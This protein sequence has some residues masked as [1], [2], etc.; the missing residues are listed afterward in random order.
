MIMIKIKQTYVNRSFTFSCLMF[1][2][3]STPSSSSGTLN[4]SRSRQKVFLLSTFPGNHLEFIAGVLIRFNFRKSWIDI[5]ENWAEWKIT[6]TEKFQIVLTGTAMSSSSSWASASKF[7][8]IKWPEWIA[9]LWR[10]TAI[11]WKCHNNA[12]I[13]KMMMMMAESFVDFTLREF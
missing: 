4:K 2:L 9:S 3:L 5:K 7:E 1:G 6:I 8:T 12:D 10:T 13:V 11:L